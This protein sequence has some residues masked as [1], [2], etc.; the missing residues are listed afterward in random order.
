MKMNRYSKPARET[1]KPYQ[2]KASRHNAYT[3]LFTT[4]RKII[5]SDKPNKH[6]NINLKK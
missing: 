1:L 2:G 4:A 6:R 3:G 5:I